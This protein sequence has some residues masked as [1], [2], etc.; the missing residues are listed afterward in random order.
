MQSRLFTALPVAPSGQSPREAPSGNRGLEVPLPARN[1][2]LPRPGP[3]APAR[4]HPDP[5]AGAHP[6][7]GTP[8]SA[9]LRREANL[10]LRVHSHAERG[11]LT[12]P[13]RRGL[14]RVAPPG[15]LLPVPQRGAVALR[16]EGGGPFKAGGHSAARAQWL[17]CVTRWGRG[18]VRAGSRVAP[19][20]GGLRPR[21]SSGLRHPL[22]FGPPAVSPCRAQPRFPPP[23]GPERSGDVAARS[24]AGARSRAAAPGLF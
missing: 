18:R 7:P 4:S 9:A 19:V 24:G 23:A 11:A 10:R 6:R 3:A 20:P 12:V 5:P 2:Q 8:V 16:A 1:T 15:P 22:D 17:G 13:G 14:R 21:R